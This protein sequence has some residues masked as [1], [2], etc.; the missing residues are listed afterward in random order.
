MKEPRIRR[1]EIAS[2]TQK[3]KELSVFF[4]SFS[5]SYIARDANVA[6]HRCASR[7]TS[8]RRICMWVNYKAHGLQNNWSNVKLFDSQKKSD[9]T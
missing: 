1:F 8:K 9:R 3:V 2:I 5:I 6:A 4:T 7:A